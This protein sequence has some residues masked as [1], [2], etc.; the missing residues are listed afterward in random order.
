RDCGFN[1]LVGGFDSRYYRLEAK[2]P[3]AFVPHVPCRIIR[4][5]DKTRCKHIGPIAAIQD[6]CTRLYSPRENQVQFVIIKAGAQWQ[7]SGV[8]C[9]AMHAKPITPRSSQAGY[10]SS[11]VVTSNIQVSINVGGAIGGDV[12]L[13]KRRHADTDIW[14][15]NVK[16]T[17]KNRERK[18][19]TGITSGI[20]KLS[21][22]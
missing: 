20:N 2:L 22:H 9:D 21:H 3:I 7:H 15:V 14:M 17:I 19:L 18:S 8:I 11:V 16:T 4:I 6:L 1:L 5:R 10:M 12:V 13:Q